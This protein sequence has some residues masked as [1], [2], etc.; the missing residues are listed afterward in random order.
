MQNRSTKTRTLR[1]S[2]SLVLNINEYITDKYSVFIKRF[3]YV[4]LL[5]PFMRG[6]F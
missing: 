6:N 5:C 3:R 4:H 2:V 1:F